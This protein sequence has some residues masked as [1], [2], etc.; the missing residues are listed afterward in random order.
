[1]VLLERRRSGAGRSIG[2]RFRPELSQSNIEDSDLRKRI[3]DAGYRLAV[4]GDELSSHEADWWGASLDGLRR[5]VSM[6]KVQLRDR[7]RRML[8]GNYSIPTSFLVSCLV[9][10]IAAGLFLAGLRVAGLLAPLVIVL[11][12]QNW[13][14]SLARAQGSR[15]AAAGLFFLHLDVLAVNAGIVW[16][17][18]E[19]LFGKKY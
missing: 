17:F 5:T 11:L 4:V 2:R 13:L 6:T 19:Y 7:F 10:W 8:R 3:T 9:P 15:A 14:R 18:L 16:G 12:N 1:V